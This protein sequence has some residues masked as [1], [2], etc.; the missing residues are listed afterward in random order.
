MRRMLLFSSAA[1]LVIIPGGA[2]VMAALSP[3]P[4][5][6]IPVGFW[7]IW[8]LLSLWSMFYAPAVVNRLIPRTAD[9]HQRG[10]AYARWG[11]TLSLINIVWSV[12]EIVWLG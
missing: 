11:I 9:N 6:T 10:L 3:R 8:L 2:C 7:V 12:V 5:H 4:R 1:L